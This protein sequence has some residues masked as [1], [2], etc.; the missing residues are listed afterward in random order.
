MRWPVSVSPD[1]CAVHSAKLLSSQ[2]LHSLSL[3]EFGIEHEAE[4][5]N[6]IG[7][8]YQE[9]ATDVDRSLAILGSACGDRL[10][11]EMD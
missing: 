2:S 5:F 10:S 9:A 6:V 8:L 11:S 7:D 4:E 3:N 1:F